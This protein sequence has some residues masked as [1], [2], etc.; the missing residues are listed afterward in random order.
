LWEYYLVYRSIL[1]EDHVDRPADEVEHIL[2]PRIIERLEQILV[3][4]NIDVENVSSIHNT[5]SGFR[6]A[7]QDA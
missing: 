1:G 6:K 5:E 4:E 3:A 7:G 2:T